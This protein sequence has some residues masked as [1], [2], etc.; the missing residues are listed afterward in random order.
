MALPIYPTGVRSAG[1]GWALG[2]A[3]SIIGPIIGGIILYLNGPAVSSMDG[4]YLRFLNINNNNKVG[5]FW[6]N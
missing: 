5:L 6:K 1:V 2:K 3:N 4:P